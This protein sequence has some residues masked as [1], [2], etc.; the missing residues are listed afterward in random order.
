M[1]F[2]I[3][4]IPRDKNTEADKLTRIASAV[5]GQW[6]G[7]ITLLNAETK[8]IALEIFAIE[9]VRDWRIPIIRF[10]KI[11]EIQFDVSSKYVIAKFC[12]FRDHVYKRSFP[13]PYLRCLSE[14]EGEY[15]LIEIHIGSTGGHTSY[16]VI[17]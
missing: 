1:S 6:E 12:L 11:G 2:E 4:Q 14:Q 9:E 10:L 7:D 15:I 13:H 3:V 17:A 5:K 8:I 16:Q